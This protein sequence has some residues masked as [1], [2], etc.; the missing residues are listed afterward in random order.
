MN[1][2]NILFRKWLP[3]CRVLKLVATKDERQEILKNHL[4]HD[5]FDVCLTSY[6]GVNLSLHYLNKFKW[7]YVFID[8]A[9]KIKNEESLLSLVIKQFF[10]HPSSLLPPPP[11]FLLPPPSLFHFI[12]LI[13][14]FVTFTPA[15]K[16]C[17]QAHRFRIIYTN[18]GLS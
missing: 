5:K 15:T 3:C 14:T 8:E 16:S 4:K 10:F 2:F 17:L 13:R 18:S 1:S 7:K 11:Y 12:F 6:Q 9:H